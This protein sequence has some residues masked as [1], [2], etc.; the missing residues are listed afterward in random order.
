MYEKILAVDVGYGS[1]KV[2]YGDTNGIIFKKFKIPTVV[3]IVGNHQSIVKDD[4]VLQYKD[5][6]YYVGED[7]YAL[8]SN[9]IIDILD[10]DH[11]EYFAPL[12][13]YHITKILGEAP[14]RIVT[15]LSKTQVGQSG[16]IQKCIE[17][18]E[19]NNI[20]V[21]FKEVNV[22]PQGVPSKLTLEKYGINYPQIN[23]EFLD[24]TS[25]IAVDIG[26]NTLDLF[27]SIN[28]KASAH[29]AEGIE[30]WG[31]MKVASEVKKLIAE[32]KRF[33]RTITLKEAMLI[34]DSGNYQLRGVN[35]DLSAELRVL[36][37]QYLEKIKELVETRYGTVLDKMNSFYLLGGGS[38]FFRELNDNFIKVPYAENEFY[39][40]IGFYLRYAGARNDK[41][42]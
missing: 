36:K 13:I 16:H 17:S 4:R 8:E 2:V 24:K 42:Q 37:E 38:V 10:Y 18:F 23:T 40:A 3:G 7:A 22:L 26:F 25:Y 32:D 9:K 41:V 29:L 30:G 12:I 33:N 28:G 27:Q 6:M 34:L 20:P 35:Y 14:D 31:V 21:H 39:N 11:L 19:V 15:G 5:G 1:T